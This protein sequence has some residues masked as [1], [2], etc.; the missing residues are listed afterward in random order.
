MKGTVKMT[1]AALLLCGS[2]QNYCYAHGFNK[3]QLISECQTISTHLHQLAKE[4]PNNYCIGDIEGVANSL[5]RV[6]EQLGLDE[7]ETILAAIKYAELELKQIK[8][9]RSYC[10]QFTSMINPIIHEVKNTGDQME[11]FMN[12]YL[13]T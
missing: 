12:S 10:A 6:G 13:T 9:N 5:A 1:L 4:N 3:S 2:L 11:V 8:S 7:P